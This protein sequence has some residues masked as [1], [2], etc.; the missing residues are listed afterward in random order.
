MK[1]NITKL[2][3]SIMLVVMAVLLLNMQV[4][5]R[6]GVNFKV[7]VIKIPLYLKVLDFFD[8]HY[9]YKNLVAKI[10]KKSDSPGDRVMKLFNWTSN[11]IKR[12]PSGY[13]IVDDHVW[14]IIVRGYGTDDQYQDVFT[15]LC[16]YAGV[17]AFFEFIYTKDNTKVISLSFVKLGKAWRVF[18][19]YN[20]VFL[21]DKSGKLAD[22]E[23]IKKK[24]WLLGGIAKDIEIEYYVPF[25][26]NL[27]SFER[28]GLKRAN[29]QSPLNR[30][31]FQVGKWLKK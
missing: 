18:D 14:H 15:T 25:L 6:Q 10:I 12:A 2:V 16:N 27:P 29:I 22:L 24:D 26:D 4:T 31:L 20:G 8:R 28:I 9:N 1:K 11:N 5:T 3:M 13:P 7:S 19:A 30:F 21:Q 23:Q 17:D